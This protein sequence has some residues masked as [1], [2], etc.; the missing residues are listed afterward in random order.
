MREHAR[1]DLHQQAWACWCN[2]AAARTIMT[3]PE[4]ER[5]LLRGGTPQLSDWLRLSLE[6]FAM[7]EVQLERARGYASLSDAKGEEAG[8]SKIPEVRNDEATEQD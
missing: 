4:E 3:Q 8:L 5:Q 7:K 1:S 2:P 6:G